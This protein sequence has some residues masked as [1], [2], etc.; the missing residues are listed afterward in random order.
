MR[1]LV[2]TVPAT[3]H[4]L[5]LVPLAE[6]LNR[7]GHQVLWATGP[8][9]CEHLQGLGMA[10][11]SVSPS[12]KA[13]FDEMAARQPQGV[14][15]ASTSRWIGPLL[16]GEI[17]AHFMIKGLL[18]CG[19]DFEPE[20]VLF[21]SRCYAAPVLAH[22]MNALPV[23]QAV[24]TLLPPEREALVAEA[25]APLWREFGLEPPAHAG[26]FDGLTFS[27]FPESLDDPGPYGELTVHRL[28]PPGFTSTRPDWLDRWLRDQRRETLIYAT[29]GT[30]HGQSRHI[31]QA[32]LEGVRDHQVAMLMTIGPEGDADS[33]GPLPPRTRIERFVPQDAVLPACAAVISHAGSGTTLG[34]LAHGLPQVLLPQGADQF[35]NTE[36]CEAAGLAR[37][38]LPGATTPDAIRSALNDVLT[39]ESYRAN[40][41]HVRAEMHGAMSRDDA[42]R[43]IE[44]SLH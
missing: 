20:V 10:A 17:G 22:A 43:L 34:A 11:R 37:G 41:G 28:A 5:P 32:I 19:H 33:L 39:D 18:A 23:L 4:V 9:Q 6:Q 24:T 2:A 40:V 14:G 12:I 21:E 42:V 15:D 31:L 1:V 26:V 44:R 13:W 36:R 38:L 16:F 7:R 3:G 8:E 35:I 25:V 30:T 29:L 27:A